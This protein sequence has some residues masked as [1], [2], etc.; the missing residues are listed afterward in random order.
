MLQ[1]AQ[2]TAAARTAKIADGAHQF[3]GMMIQQMLKGMNFGASPDADSDGGGEQNALQS[4]GTEA[5][6]RSL[7]SHGGFGLASRIIQQVTA[8]DHAKGAGA[9]GGK[10]E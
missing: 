9:A 4:Y 2:G 7:A 10:V 5:L 6:A 1:P 8:E 3:E